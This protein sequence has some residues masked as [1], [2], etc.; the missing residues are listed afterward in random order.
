MEMYSPLPS[1]CV[2]GPFYLAQIEAAHAGKTM[3]IKLFDAGDTN[4][5]AN[6]EI[7]IPTAAGWSATNFDYTASQGTTNSGVVQLQQLSGHRR[8]QRRDLLR[9]AAGSTAA[10]SRSR[11]RSRSTYTAQQSGW[12]KIRYN[13]TGTGTTAT[14]ITTWQVQIRGNPVHLILP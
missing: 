5:D 8:A 4:Q 12:W 11:S 14:D 13:M 10:G 2:L 7:L 1:W 3:E 9:A 6:I